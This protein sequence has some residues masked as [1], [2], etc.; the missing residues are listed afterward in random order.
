MPARSIAFET[1]YPSDWQ[2]DTVQDDVADT[3]PNVSLPTTDEW[4]QVGLTAGREVHGG[5]QS[6]V[7][8][9][10]R[11]GE[12]LAV[13]LT[14]RRFV[15]ETYFR[16]LEMVE[17]LASNDSNVIGPTRIGGS[18]AV[19]VGEWFAVAY[20]FVEGR[21]P[22][23]TER[24]DVTVMASALA[25]LHRSLRDIPP[26]DI[27]FVAALRPAEYMR[28]EFGSYQL[29]HG[30]YSNSNVMLSEDRVSVIDFDD[31]GYGPIEFEVG[32][33]LYMVLF[34]ATMQH[35]VDEYERFREWFVE[36]YSAQTNR[37]L[38]SGQLDM[39]I[40][41]RKR[42]LADWLDDLPSAPIG[43]RTAPSTWLSEL[44]RFVE[45]S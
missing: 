7:V 23:L 42:A 22:V 38:H 17:I 39:A 3:G 15:D 20:P 11:R 36:T 45:T 21:T 8:L 29:L 1:C 35:R 30:D 19:E 31:A 16:R 18:T 43:I 2:S 44:R 4:T 33:T 5:H 26:Q 27:P 40:E 13:K 14:D 34:D 24:A 9:A 25:S 41:L 12:S 32:N 37:T 10:E 28:D 6:R